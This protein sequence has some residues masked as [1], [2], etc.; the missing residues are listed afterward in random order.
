MHPVIPAL[1]SL[2]RIASAWIVCALVWSIFCCASA[3][4]GPPQF[5]A[6]GLE[7]SDGAEAPLG[8]ED[9]LDFCRSQDINEIYVSISV[10]S[11]ATR[12]GACSLDRPGPSQEH[13]RGSFAIEH[14]RR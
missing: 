1:D 7:E 12:K 5:M 9:L 4:T 2:R 3:Q 8:A 13:S 6:C 10:R 11:E 14:R